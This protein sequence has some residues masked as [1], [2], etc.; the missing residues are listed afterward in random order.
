MIVKYPNPILKKEC[1]KVKRGNKELAKVLNLLTRELSAAEIGVGLSA[2]QI[3]VGLSVFA[4]KKGGIMDFFLNPEITDTFGADKVCPFLI[5]KNGQKKHFLEGCLSFPKIYGA[6]KRWL[7]IKVKFQTTDFATEE[8]IIAGFD[9]VV[10]QHELDHLNGIVFI[11]RIKAE[12]GK[13]YREE[14]GKLEK[15]RVKNI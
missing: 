6:V 7:K 2:P 12:G 1:Q 9:A 4:L 15:I 8:R 11:D 13:L 3:G 5:G 10:F 14:N